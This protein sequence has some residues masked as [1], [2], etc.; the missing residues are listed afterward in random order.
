MQ[1]KKTNNKI[2]SNLERKLVNY[3]NIIKWIA[4]SLLLSDKCDYVRF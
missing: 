3:H 1:K 2:I 4:A